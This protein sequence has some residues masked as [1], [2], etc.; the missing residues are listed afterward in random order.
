M[1]EARVGVLISAI[2]L[3]LG[4]SG[5]TLTIDPNFADFTWLVRIISPEDLEPTTYSLLGVIGK[6][7][8]GDNLFLGVILGLFSVVF[9]VAKLGLYWVAAGCSS[10]I[11]RASGLL[12]WVHRA[13]K[14]SMAEVFALAL[15]VVVVQTLP[16][17]ST[18]SVKW[19]AY[20]FV[21][22]ILGSIFVSFALDKPSSHSSSN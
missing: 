11:G 18:A 1:S 4:L 12:R 7:L 6:L 13:G 14:F 10:N 17:G 15:I 8:D 22:S 2:L 3:G 20:V 9:P 5:P 19:G 21:A 16:G